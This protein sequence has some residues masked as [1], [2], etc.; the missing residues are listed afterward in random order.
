MC[1]ANYSG[2]FIHFTCPFLSPL[3]L[4]FLSFSISF[5]PNFVFSS[6]S[7]SLF[8][9]GYSFSSHFSQ[10]SSL[11]EECHSFLGIHL[12][13]RTLVWFSLEE[14]KRE[15]EKG[16]KL[17]KEKEWERSLMK[18]VL[19][20][21]STIPLVP[22]ILF[23][24]QR[25]MIFFFLSSLPSFFLTWFFPFMITTR[26]RSSRSNRSIYNT[27][28]CLKTRREERRREGRNHAWNTTLRWGLINSP[29]SRNFSLSFCLTSSPFFHK[30]F[31]SFSHTSFL[32]VFSRRDS[33]VCVL[34]KERTVREE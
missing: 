30:F 1:R 23:L 5:I 31:L 17:E 22:L 21:L 8:F 12:L 3:S 4:S 15:R 9:F 34:C 13:S 26:R 14:N 19:Q 16:R 29:S 2:D 18:V 24:F 6:P 7:W 32:S 33:K 27:I 20:L 10:S 25:M 28:F 11:N